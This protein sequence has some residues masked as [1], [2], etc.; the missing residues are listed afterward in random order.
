[1]RPHPGVGRF[2]LLLSD[3]GYPLYPVGVYE[4]EG[5]LCLNF[6]APFSLAHHTAQ[7]AD[8]ADRLAS[9]QVM[10][11]LACCLPEALHGEFG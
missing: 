5:A 11:A 6:G 4:A 7:S 3:M 1:M 9:E 2:L 10:R 8:E